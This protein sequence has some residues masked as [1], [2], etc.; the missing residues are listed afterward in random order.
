MSS[1]VDWMFRSRETG[2]ILIGQPANRPIKVFAAT[3]VVGVLLPRSSARTGLAVVALSA[4]TWW[5]GDE[6]VRGA[7]PFRRLSGV[8]AIGA[9]ALL[10]LRGMRR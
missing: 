3:T 8:V 1:F 7:N 9:V 5:A 6:I 4:L 10:T 2:R